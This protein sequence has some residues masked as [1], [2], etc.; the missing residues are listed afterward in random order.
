MDKVEI[1]SRLNSGTKSIDNIWCGLKIKVKWI[2]PDNY[3]NINK[4]KMNR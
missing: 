4:S 1:I 3:D 2:I